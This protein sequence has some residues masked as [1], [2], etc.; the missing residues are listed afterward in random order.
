MTCE[1]YGV[2]ADK[3]CMNGDWFY[4]TIYDVFGNGG[5]SQK[6]FDQTT[7]HNE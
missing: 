7:L 4:P 6:G 3:T 2:N 5:R 1:D